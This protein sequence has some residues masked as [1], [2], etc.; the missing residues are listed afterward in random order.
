ML[1]RNTIQSSCRHVMF[2][3][4]SSCLDKQRHQHKCKIKT[5]GLTQGKKRHWNVP[6]PSALDGAARWGE[7]KQAPSLKAPRNLWSSSRAQRSTTIPQSWQILLEFHA[8]LQLHRNLASS[9]RPAFSSWRVR[10]AQHCNFVTLLW[11]KRNYMKTTY[12][13]VHYHVSF[14]L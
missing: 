3:P 12:L 8:K 5:T 11:K 2:L 6:R 10:L 7:S 9:T 14:T 1:I 4:H 13:E